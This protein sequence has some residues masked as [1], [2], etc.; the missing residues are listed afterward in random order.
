VTFAPVETGRCP[1][2]REFGYKNNVAVLFVATKIIIVSE[3]DVY[4]PLPSR[5]AGTF[6]SIL[7]ALNTNNMNRVPSPTDTTHPSTSHLVTPADRI[8]SDTCNQ[9]QCPR[10]HWTEIAICNRRVVDIPPPSCHGVTKVLSVVCV[11]VG[12]PALCNRLVVVHRTTAPAPDIRF[13]GLLER[14]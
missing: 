4:V 10:S 7:N 8:H 12:I 2:T 14:F 13:L 1:A 3:W 5:R 11:F 9:L 6:E